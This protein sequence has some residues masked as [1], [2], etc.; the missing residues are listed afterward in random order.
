MIC[1]LFSNKRLYQKFEQPLFLVVRL[2]QK[3]ELPLFCNSPTTEAVG[4]NFVISLEPTGL[5]VG[6]RISNYI[7][8]GISTLKI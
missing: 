5:P 3:F 6:A 2:Y 1:L 4:S 8:G 7:D